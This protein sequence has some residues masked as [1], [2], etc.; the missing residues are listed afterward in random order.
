MKSPGKAKDERA[1]AQAALAAIRAELRA[2]RAALALLIDGGEDQ[3]RT[4][5]KKVIAQKSGATQGA[6]PAAAEPSTGPTSRSRGRK[7]VLAAYKA[8]RGI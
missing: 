1:K 2:Q 6:V 3:R 5:L 8:K 7:Q 4:R